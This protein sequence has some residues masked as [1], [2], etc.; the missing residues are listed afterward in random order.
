M[1]VKL[2]FAGILEDQKHPLAVVEMAVEAE[3]IWVA[4]VAVDLNLPPYLLFH[5][6]LL[7]LAFM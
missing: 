7:Q 5:L 3:D 1:L 4:E 6:S 2:P